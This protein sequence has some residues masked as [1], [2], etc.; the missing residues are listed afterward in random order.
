MHRGELA[1]LELTE[2]RDFCVRTSV[3]IGISVALVLLGGFAV[4]FAVAAA[5]WN[6]PDRGM[7]LSLLALAYFAVSGGFAFFA[8][9][10]LNA[11]QPFSETTR[12]LREDCACIQEMINDA[13]R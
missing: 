6:R 10:R 3:M 9:R 11:W 13:K 2:A 12:Q 8:A 5:V 7:I 4:T 1:A